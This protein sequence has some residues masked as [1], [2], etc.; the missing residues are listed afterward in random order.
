MN[1]KYP[2]PIHPSPNT[3][4]LVSKGSMDLDDFAD[5]VK[6]LLAMVDPD[7]QF[8]EDEPTGNSPDKINLPIIT[9]DI[10]ERVR[11]ESHPSLGPILFD[12]IKDP[13]NPESTI[14]RYRMW[15]DTEVEFKIFHQTNREAKIVMREFEEFLF[16]YKGYFKELGISDIIF[17]AERPPQVITRWQ[18]EVPVR[19]LRYLVRIE[20]ITTVRSN[21][22]LQFGQVDLTVERPEGHEVY[23]E[24]Y[25]LQKS[26]KVNTLTNDFMKAYRNQT[27]I[28]D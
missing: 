7:V 5:K 28:E 10:H 14:K 3:E 9:F 16:I 27:R 22:H 25:P 18:M 13:E 17:L 1:Q 15:F 2:A 26:A 4:T 20:R 8:V 12:N 6:E 23:R 11:S 24:K 19:T 21:K